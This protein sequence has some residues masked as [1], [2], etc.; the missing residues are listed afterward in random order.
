LP[1]IPGSKDIDIHLGAGDLRVFVPDDA[2]VTVN[3]HSSAGDINC[4][5]QQASGLGQSE[6]ASS[7]DLTDPNAL[8]LTIDATVGTGDLEVSRG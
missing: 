4:L 2:A 8:K 5:G 7:G 6:S 1:N 3:C